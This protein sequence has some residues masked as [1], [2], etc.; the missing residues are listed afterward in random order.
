MMIS[1]RKRRVLFSPQQVHVLERKFQINRYLSAADRENLA[2]SINLSATQ[3]K[4]WFQNQRYKCKR[5]EKEKKMDGGCYRDSDRDTDSDR[6]NDSSGSL[7]S[8]MSGIKKEEDEDRKPFMPSAV[9]SDT[10]CLP[11]ISQQAFPYQMYPSSSYMPPFFAYQAPP[12]NYPPSTYNLST[13][14]FHNL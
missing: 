4:I 6:D 2:K 14:A 12:A 7:G 8:S 3:V 11:D 1:R 10:A 5:Q 13:S 9:S